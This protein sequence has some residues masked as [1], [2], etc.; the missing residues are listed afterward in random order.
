M[1][2]GE[3]DDGAR[4]NLL[5]KTRQLVFI[6]GGS[7]TGKSSL[8]Q[9]LQAL[10]KRPQE[11]GGIYMTGKFNLKNHGQGM[12]QTATLSDASTTMRMSEGEPS[13]AIAAACGQLCGDIFAGSN[14]KQIR[15]KLVGEL[16]ASEVAVLTKV[17]P[18]LE[19]FCKVSDD[20]QN[21]G[22]EGNSRG[23][24]GRQQQKQEQT[25][26]ISG[27]PEFR[28]K[29]FQYAFRKFMRAVGSCCSNC[30]VLVVDDIQWADTATLELLQVLITD[31]SNDTLMVVGCYRPGEVKDNSFLSNLI[32]NLT[33]DS[34]SQEHGYSVTEIS[35]DNLDL[36][37]VHEMVMEAL[38]SDHNLCQT[39]AM[40]LANICYHKTL[41]NPFFVKSFLQMLHKRLLLNYNLGT[42]KWVWDEQEIE[43]STESTDNVVNLMKTRMFEMPHEA[44]KLL[45]IAA[46]L[47]SS[48]TEKILV[49]VWEELFNG[50]A[51]EL[52]VDNEK[53]DG[54]Y[55]TIKDVLHLV[56]EEGFF[57]S[58]E[59][60]G[61]YRWV[62][63]KIQESAYSLMACEEDLRALQSQI[64]DILVTCLNDRDLES[65][66]FV[67]VN[68]LNDGPV[69][70]DDKAALI[71]R[72]QLNLKAAERA[73][74]LSA[75]ESAATYATTGARYLPEDCWQGSQ[76][77][78]ALKLY[79]TA[80]ETSA[81]L[82]NV[83][84]MDKYC[85]TVLTQEVIPL[86]DKLRVYVCLLGSL[87]NR[88]RLSDAILLCLDVL[89]KL[90]CTFP[91]M[92]IL[93]QLQVKAGL[94]RLLMKAKGGTEKTLIKTQMMEDSKHLAMIKIV[95]K[96]ATCCYVGKERNLY[97]LAVIKEVDL[98][99]QYGL[100]DAA[101][102]AF[103]AAGHALASLGNYMKG[104]IMA[105]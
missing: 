31:T 30:V 70:S 89:G 13:A 79:S 87:I 25:Q 102:H 85:N 96:L 16:E 41:G 50:R 92:N 90:G 26:K 63:D 59:Q 99:D 10:V 6:K 77:E 62:H 101:P 35:L 43:Q 36:S 64:G 49:C 39:Q 34:N 61:E 69:D 100:S 40:R 21:N 78:L 55:A 51:D 66:I 97:L 73:I 82:G 38:S 60:E 48:F 72:A 29:Q 94:R 103:S 24:T 46:C 11:H 1:D 14:Q 3:D 15:Q 28:K 58:T 18:I 95:V 80:V 65:V 8:A 33:S 83:E 88:N 56:V 45:Q 74:D 44:Q 5:K 57:R 98:T 71:R 75:Y 42:L 9:T 17:I 84:A 32:G 47:G 4:R 54:G 93:R 53:S 76:Y 68:L 20:T 81:S 12:N 104:P 91:K 67:A 27:D 23:A 52:G 7:G 22:S 37:Q 2:N 19:E 86:L 105:N